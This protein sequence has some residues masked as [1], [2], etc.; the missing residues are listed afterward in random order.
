MAIAGVLLCGFYC[1][2]RSS[3]V[4]ED[5]I[6]HVSLSAFVRTNSA[7]AVYSVYLVFSRS[8][9]FSI[10][11]ENHDSSSKEMMSR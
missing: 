6:E 9:F 11:R 8:A 4:F 10:S 5:A 3:K 1:S 2:P 7:V